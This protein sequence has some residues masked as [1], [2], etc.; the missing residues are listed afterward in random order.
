MENVFLKTTYVLFIILF[1]L[2]KKHGCPLHF[3]LNQ[4]NKK[5][6]SF[7]IIKKKINYWKLCLFLTQYMNKM[8]YM[9]FFW[10]IANIF[11]QII[12]KNK[13]IIIINIIYI[14]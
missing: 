6:A 10:V 2:T 8:F 13:F 9:L 11:F 5:E 14:Y 12:F 4:Q 1:C 7:I 3:K